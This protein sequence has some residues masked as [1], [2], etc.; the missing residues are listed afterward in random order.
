MLETECRC[1]TT[2]SCSLYVLTLLKSSKGAT[3]LQQFI[4]FL[5]HKQSTE[6]KTQ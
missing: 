1:A 3:N 4:V 6:F 5:T 2:F